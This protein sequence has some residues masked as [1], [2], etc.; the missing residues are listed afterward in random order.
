M[1]DDLL[2]SVSNGLVMAN[3]AVAC[4]DD[5]LYAHTV[6]CFYHIHKSIAEAIRRHAQHPGAHVSHANAYLPENSTRRQAVANPWC[7]CAGGTQGLGRLQASQRG[8]TA[9]RLLRRTCAT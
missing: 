1:F 8:W 7:C 4:T 9:Q 3:L 2:C 6:A 5:A